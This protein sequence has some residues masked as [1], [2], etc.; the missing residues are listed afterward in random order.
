MF[1]CLKCNRYQF[2]GI[3]TDYSNNTSDICIIW[4]EIYQIY[5]NLEE[6]YGDHDKKSSLVDYCKDHLTELEGNYDLELYDIY[7]KYKN[8][9]DFILYEKLKEKINSTNLYDTYHNYYFIVTNHIKN[10]DHT[11]HYL[12]VLELLKN[13]L[14]AAKYAIIE[15]KHFKWLDKYKKYIEENIDDSDDLYGFAENFEEDLLYKY[16]IFNN[17]IQKDTKYDKYLSIIKIFN[18]NLKVDHDTTRK[19]INPDP[20]LPPYTY[21]LKYL[22]HL[23]QYFSLNQVSKLTLKQLRM[24]IYIYVGREG[25][26]CTSVTFGGWDA[27]A[28]SDSSPTSAFLEKFTDEEE[29]EDEI[30]YDDI[31]Y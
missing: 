15:E 7:N 18:E 23:S 3:V 20:G 28:V 24:W 21:T 13:E 27:C 22:I 8:N 26:E 31:S 12:N 10:K 5:K 25:Y 1:H 6:D 29:D 19:C 2:G 16:C 9:D 17:L 11:H 30:D 4:L 14:C